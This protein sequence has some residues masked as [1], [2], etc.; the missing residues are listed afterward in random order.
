MAVEPG[1]PLPTALKLLARR[2]HSLRELERKLR[3]KGFEPQAIQ[4][5]LAALE[6]QRLQSDER[7]AESYVAARMARGYGPQRI[8]VELAERG[9]GDDE[10]EQ[11]LALTKGE[12]Q[13]RAQ[14]V[15]RK[16]FGSELPQDYQE[17]ARQAR[18]LQYRGFTS[19]QIRRVFDDVGLE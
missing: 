9:V 8:R 7:F 3:Q 14:E 1:N 5:C 11:Q 15:R 6:Q 16:R 10:I 2:E 13:A 12:W 17:R 4:D 18:F 19:E